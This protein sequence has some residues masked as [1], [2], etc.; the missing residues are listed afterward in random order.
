MMGQLINLVDTKFDRL[1][2]LSRTPNNRHQQTMWRCVC[3]CGNVVTVSSCNLRSKHT[4]SCGCL[5]RELTAVR[6]STHGCSRVNNHTKEYRTWQKM[7]ERCMNS[8]H[9][10]YHY[11]GG[12]GIRVC[13]RWIQSFEIFLSDMGKAPTSKH[14][15]DRIDNNGH[16]E[17]TNCRWATAKEQANNRG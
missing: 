10:N 4:R 13:S 5:A 1:L 7:K 2:V 9:M 14:S 17:P 11:Y 6:S 16:Y 15:I 12:R 8:N 3:N